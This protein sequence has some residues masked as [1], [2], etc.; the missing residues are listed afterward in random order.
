MIPVSGSVSGFGSRTDPPKKEDPI[1]S[2]K[3][4][5]PQQGTTRPGSL[6]DAARRSDAKTKMLLPALLMKV[7]SLVLLALC[8]LFLPYFALMLLLGVF[9]FSDTPVLLYIFAGAALSFV[10]IIG[11]DAV[12]KM[13]NYSL[14]IAGCLAGLLQVTCLCFPQPLLALWVLFIL[15]FVDVR[16]NFD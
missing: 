13:E 7:T 16:Q 14:A 9:G 8:A 4:P 15:G 11:M 2:L 10:N 6:R 12:M 3:K 1:S 5:F